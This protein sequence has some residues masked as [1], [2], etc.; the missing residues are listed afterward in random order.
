M[1]GLPCFAQA[2]ASVLIPSL[3]PDIVNY[4]PESGGGEL[5]S[6]CNLILAREEE[7]KSLKLRVGRHNRV[8]SS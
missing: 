1:G 5:L 2:G 3:A 4:S 6:H 8:R 7:A